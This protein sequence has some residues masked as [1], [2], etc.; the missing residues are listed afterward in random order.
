MSKVAAPDEQLIHA[1][2]PVSIDKTQRAR[3]T[4][5]ALG[6][7]SIFGQNAI[8]KKRQCERSI[9]FNPVKQRVLLQGE[10]I[11]PSDGECNQIDRFMLACW[12]VRRII[13]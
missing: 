12:F 10:V 6:T 3:L 2:F 13:V 11:T 1:L 8:T 4:D 9:T 7:V 5:D